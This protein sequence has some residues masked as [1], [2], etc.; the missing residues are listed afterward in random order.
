MSAAVVLHSGGPTP[1]INASLLGVV[2]EARRHAGITALYGARHGIGGVMREDFADLF[3]I[4]EKMLD[5]ISR[6][7]SSALGTSRDEVREE[8]LERIFTVIAKRAVRYLLYTGG[9]GSMGAACSVEHYAKDR[10]YQL[11]VVGIPKTID[12]DLTGTDHTPGYATAARFFACAARDIGADNRS[13]PGQVEFVEVLGRNAGWLVAATALAR[14]DPDDAPHLIYFPEARLPLEQLLDDVDRVYGR[15]GRCVAAV[16]EGQLDENGQ[17]FGADVRS[18]SG[19]TLAMNVAHRLAI[20]VMEKLKLR[21][22]SEKPGLLAR[23][24]SAYPCAAY[25]CELDW[26]EARRCGQAAVRAA[27][28]GASGVMVG[29]A[30]EAG[31]AYAVRTTLVPLEE[32]AHQKLYP[33]EWRNAAGNDVQPAFIDYA[34]PLVGAIPGYAAL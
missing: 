26:N 8:D 25:P 13:L 3:S 5:A 10:G 19:G 15:L 16:C 17:P 27:I 22:R 34:A 29:L 21:A 23:S 24:G 11:R 30:R 7:P 12:N 20:L 28:E 9:N 18:G 33:P 1:V 2:E 14:H 32:A 4:D 6:A 31:A